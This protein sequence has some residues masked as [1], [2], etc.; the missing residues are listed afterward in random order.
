[1]NSSEFN[2][3]L[4]EPELALRLNPDYHDH[5]YTNFLRKKLFPYFDT[6]PKYNVIPSASFIRKW[7]DQSKANQNI[8]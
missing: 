7:L 6:V 1:M 8:A 4:T 3:C 2:S 5:D